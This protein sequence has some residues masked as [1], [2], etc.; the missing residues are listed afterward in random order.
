M[1]PAAPIPPSAG[2]PEPAGL[3]RLA[4]GVLIAP[5]ALVYSF[6]SSS[7]P[8]GQNVNKRATR[9]ELRI[10]IDDIPIH[11]QAA[12]RLAALAGRRVTAAGEIVIE[13]DVHRS[14]GRNKDECLERLGELVRQAVVKPK[15]RRATK[16]TAGSKRRRIEE[17]KRRGQIKR[18]RGDAPGGE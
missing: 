9:A 3:V 10:R 2:E 18:G 12:L 5:G 8:G 4:P 17:K 13:S 14:Q 15:V 11:P 6:T 7:G 1:S 16:P